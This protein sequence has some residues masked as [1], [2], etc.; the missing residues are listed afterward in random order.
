MLD[1]P[2]GWFDGVVTLLMAV[3][4]FMLNLYR[5]KVDRLEEQNSAMVTRDELQRHMD[6]IRDDKLRMHAENLDRLKDIGSDIR[7]VHVRIDQVFNG[8]NGQ[9]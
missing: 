5:R 1:A 7:A 2:Q 6:L 4:G 9:H 8:K 3:I